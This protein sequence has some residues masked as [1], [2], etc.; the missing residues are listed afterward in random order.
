ML[1]SGKIRLTKKRHIIYN[2]YKLRKRKA[3]E[4]TISFAADILWLRHRKE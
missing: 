4:K 2:V 1:S 3:A